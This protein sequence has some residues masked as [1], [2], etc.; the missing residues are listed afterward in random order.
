MKP[1]LHKDIHFE[2]DI[3]F[4]QITKLR[5]EERLNDHATAYIT[6]VLHDQVSISEVYRLTINSNFRIKVLEN[7]DEVV[8]FA[9]VLVG[10]E[11]KSL[12]DVK[13]LSVK[14][15]S[16]SFKLDIQKQS[17][18]FQD[19]NNPYRSIFTQI[20][21][22]EHK[23]IILDTAS[24]MQ[25]QGRFIVQYNETD[26]NFLKRLASQ[27]N[28]IIYAHM[29][30]N[31]PQVGI[32][33]P[34]GKSYIEN[35]HQFE[36]SRAIGEHMRNASNFPRW[37]NL[38]FISDV[39]QSTDIY[40]LCDVLI[41]DGVEYLIAEKICELLQGILL[42]TYRLQPKSSFHQNIMYNE[43]L[44]G[45]SIEGQVLEAEGDKVKLHLEIDQ[46]QNSGTAYWF[47]CD[48]PYVAEGHTGTY[49]MPELGTVAHLYFPN[50]DE[51]QAYIRPIL[52]RGGA[53]NSKTGSPD[54]KYLETI[55]GKELM[56]SPDSLSLTAKHGKVHM[57]MSEGGGITFA[58]QG[59][60]YI[61]GVEMNLSGETICMKANDKISL[62]TNGG[63]ILINEDVDIRG[64]SGT[65][66][67]GD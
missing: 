18:S 25:P 45:T 22:D 56:L 49:I 21:Q 67:I 9:G 59:D 20:V 35:P 55:D 32:G 4:V 10:L 30:A 5:I 19:I 47:N 1:I 14:L 27:L 41:I 37:G 28:A 23:G 52:R 38:D 6:G 17:R 12:I 31:K 53:K 65:K 58:S 24:N 26:W 43:K 7:G 34:L 42:N 33:T 40:S 64:V 13:Y 11:I 50:R 54:T 2:G 15:K 44:T 36:I 51:R 8:I 29:E 66:L 39:F 62:M 60:V 48:T 3:D 57:T 61:K 46:H 16:H 63:S